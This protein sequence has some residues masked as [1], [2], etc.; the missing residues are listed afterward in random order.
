MVI[1]TNMS[2]QRHK[3]FLALYE[4]WMRAS[5]SAVETND[6]IESASADAAAVA[7]FDRMTA[8]RPHVE[9]D[10]PYGI[11][12]ELWMADAPADVFKLVR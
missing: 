10:M 6:P 8:L 2:Q 1:E 5:A 12:K 11:V 3:E 4:A 7:I 9:D